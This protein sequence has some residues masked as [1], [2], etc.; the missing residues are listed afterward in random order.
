MKKNIFIILVLIL[1]AAFCKKNKETELNDPEWRKEALELSYHICEKLETCF[2]QEDLSKL[3]KDLLNYA[4]SEIKPEKCTEKTKKSRM[5][6]LKGN[7]PLKIKEISRECSLQIQKFSC[8]EIRSGAL[9]GSVPCEEMRK[10]QQGN[11]S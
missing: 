6:L 7:D 2:Q 11:G 5:Y 1:S 8:D 10:I 9:R 4:K 3:K